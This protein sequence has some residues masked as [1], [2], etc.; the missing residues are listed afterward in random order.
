[1]PRSRRRRSRSRRRRGG[2]PAGYC[3][4]PSGKSTAHESKAMCSSYGGTYQPLDD[5]CKQKYY[6]ACKKFGGEMQDGKC[7]VYDED[8]FD[9]D[10][11]SP[12][13]VFAEADAG[14]IAQAQKLTGCAAL[15]KVATGGRRRRRRKKS[16]RKSKRKKSRRKRKRSRRRRRRR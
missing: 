1:M 8:E 11:E 6:E 7:Y 5:A 14:E 4:G 13:D 9:V 12:I 15:K 16:R 2:V 10:L 3:S